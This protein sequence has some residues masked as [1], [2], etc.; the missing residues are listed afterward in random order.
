MEGEERRRKVEKEKTRK[1]EKER[2]G[3]RTVGG[4][5]SRSRRDES[6]GYT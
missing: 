6:C 2:E 1:G 3:K 4:N 5:E